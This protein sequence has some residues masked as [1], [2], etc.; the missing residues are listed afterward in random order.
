MNAEVKTHAPKRS[1]SSIRIVTKVPP[2]RELARDLLKTD[3]FD[4]RSLPEVRAAFSHIIN[5]L[6]HGK[7]P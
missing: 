2:Y 5:V 7:E 1:K 4:G 3:L 6:A